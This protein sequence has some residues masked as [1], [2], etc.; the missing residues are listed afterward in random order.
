MKTVV[1]LTIIGA[2][3]AA[4]LFSCAHNRAYLNEEADFGFYTKVGVLPFSNLSADKNASEKVTSS[5][6]SELLMLNL[7]QVA[8]MGDLQTVMKNV[9]EKI[10]ANLS[11]ELTAEDVQKIG[12]E[13]GVQGLFVGAV[14]EFGMVR[15]GQD[16]F[17]LVSVM[18]RFVDCQM[19]T[20]VWSYEVTRRGGPKFPIFSFGETHTLGEMTAKVC[21]D[22]ARSYR[23]ATE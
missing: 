8:N 15:S 16:Q 18:V 10:P 6:V 3:V 19:G 17:P 2:A 4:M 14:K 9:I 21:R 1:K 7:A 22:L 23:K 13:A 5:F 20:V 11:E 12:L